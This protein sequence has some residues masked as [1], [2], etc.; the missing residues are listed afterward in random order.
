MRT[1]FFVPLA[2][3]ISLAAAESTGPPSAPRR[4]VTDVYH[5]VRVRDDYRWLENWSDPEVR[6]WSEAQNAYARSVLDGLPDREAIGRRVREL[7][8]FPSPGYFAL[9][10]RRG[11]L[12]ALKFEPPKQQPFLVTFPSTDPPRGER[13]L[14][15]PNALDPKGGTS[16]DRYV[17]SLDGRLVAV[18]L[19][20]GGSESGTV[21]VYET[22]AGKP[23][24]D[25]IPRVNGGTAG[26]SLAWNSDASGFFYTRYPRGNE[27]PPEDRDFFQQVWFHRLGGRT[28]EDTYSLGKD[29]PRIAETTLESS[30]DGRF[31][32][33][34]VKNGDG[35]EV[36]QFLRDPAGTWAAVSTFADKAVEGQI[37]PDSALYLLSRSG[38]P[39][40]RILRLALDAPSLEKARVIVPEGEAAID[41]FVATENLLYVV[42]TVGGPHRIR[43]FDHAGKP[44]GDLPILPVSSI[45][46]VVPLPGDDLLFSNQSLLVPGAWYRTGPGGKVVRTAMARKSPADFRDSEV[47]RETATSKDGTK[48]PLTILRRKGTKLDGHRPTVLT[49]YGGFGISESPYFSQGLRLW[50]EQGGVWVDANLRGGG[51]FG[52]TW[53]LA[54]NLTKKQNVFDDF[55]ACA[56]FLIEAGYTRPERLAIE[57]GSNGGLLMGAALTQHPDLFRAVVSY[58]GIYDMLRVELSPNG[59]FNVTEYGTVKDPAQFAALHA[60]SPYHHVVD[61]ARYPAILFLTGA[62]DPR[63]DPMQSRKMTARLQA[64]T[65]SSAPILLRTSGSSGH[66][67][68]TAL[69]EELAQETDAWSFLFWQLGL[70]YRPVHTPPAKA[71]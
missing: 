27:H 62:N 10:E 65:G 2:L 39:R 53:H 46:G 35:G 45:G 71:R 68:G 56:R 21:H 70:S 43:V 63:V 64:A 19:S 1:V 40:G 50:I 3:S 16:I 8:A 31:V 13:V 44:R 14:V 17:P 61:G 60:Y 66:G 67:F 59:S 20:E 36:E 23:L 12:F 6:K 4:P 69:D 48:I 58:V 34:S 32:L 11:T 30:R 57:G 55:L 51:E 25:V 15:D 52:E 22:A 18:S 42:D 54:G 5:G 37:G 9:A 29:F 26:G 47:L 7:E 41:R 33:A 24:P 49:G 38:A 28:E